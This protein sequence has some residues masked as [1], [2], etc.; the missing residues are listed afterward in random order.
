MYVPGT[1]TE[2]ALRTVVREE[3]ARHDEERAK[4]SKGFSD[5]GSSEAELLLADLQLDEVDGNAEEPIA[6]PDDA[7]QA[8]N[9]AYEQYADENS[10]TPFLLDHHAEQ[11]KPFGVRFGRG[12]FKIYD[13]HS[14]RNLYSITT[15]SGQ[16]YSGTVDGCIAPY[17]LMAS[18]AGK[19]S[20]I[21]YEHKQS[22]EQKRAYRDAHPEQYKVRALCRFCIALGWCSSQARATC[23]LVCSLGCSARQCNSSERLILRSGCMLPLLV[24]WWQTFN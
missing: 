4:S 8:S 10:G 11:L 20:R 22:Q 2:D 16:R 17:G 23:D 14:H 6:L 19:H 5:V 9:F 15:G 7:P 12:G 3:L 21:A 24:Y 13:L 1:S 18:S